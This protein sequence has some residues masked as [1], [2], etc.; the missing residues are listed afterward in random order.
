MVEN[1]DN[2][3]RLKTAPG[4]QSARELGP[5]SYSYKEKNSADIPHFNAYNVESRKMVLMNLFAGQE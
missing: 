2:L 3:W 4:R 1:A 5:Q